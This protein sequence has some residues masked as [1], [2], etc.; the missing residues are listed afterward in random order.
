M[1]NTPSEYEE[2]THELCAHCIPPKTTYYWCQNCN[3][4]RFQQDFDKWTSGN[5]FIDKF[6]QNAQL[7]AR[8]LWEVVEWISYDR[9]RNVQYLTRGGFSTIYKAIWLDGRIEEWD[10]KK[11]QWKRGKS[12]KHEEDGLYVVLK[13][14]NYS[15]NINEDSLNE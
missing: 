7:K 3:S 4:K 2:Q 9:L 11:Q 6:I 5:K 12:K 10:G 1:E 15:S 8:N 14:L 13:S